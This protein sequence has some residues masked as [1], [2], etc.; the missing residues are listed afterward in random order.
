[1]KALAKA[2]FG[3][4]SSYIYLI[5]VG[6][7]LSGWFYV[8]GLQKKVVGLKDELRVEKAESLAK[9]GTIASQARQGER[10][11]AAKRDLSDAETKKLTKP[12]QAVYV[13]AVSLSVLLLSSCGSTKIN[14]RPIILTNGQFRCDVA[15]IPLTDED[16]AAE[17][18][19]NLIS[20]YMLRLA[21]AGRDCRKQLS[22]IKNVLEVQGATITDV[23]VIDEVVKKKRFGLF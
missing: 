11:A 10:K 1:M 18:A 15:P 20:S 5:G 14:P 3:G 22:E 2:L 4:G 19:D 9:D 12:R 6:V 13:L 16:L 23:L 17:N 7:I 8:T 21:S